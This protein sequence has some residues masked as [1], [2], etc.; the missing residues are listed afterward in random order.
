PA[1]CTPSAIRD[2]APSCVSPGLPVPAT[3]SL[4]PYTTLFRSL[5]LF[6]MTCVLF[7]ARL[8]HPLLEPEEG[9]YAEIP[10]EMLTEG[11]FLTPVLQDRKSTRL[12]SSHEW[13][14]YA[15]FCLKKIL[16]QSIEDRNNSGA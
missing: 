12:N 13:M 11:R 2:I 9:R 15:V 10:R 7:F 1:A 8:D 4:F 6:V 14:S 5:L 3:S 16:E